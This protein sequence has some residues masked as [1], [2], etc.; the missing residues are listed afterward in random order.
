MLFNAQ[1]FLFL[2][3]DRWLMFLIGNMI[4]SM[5]IV[6]FW[7][8]K[9]IPS[10]IMDLHPM[11][12]SYI[13]LSISFSSYSTMSGSAKNALLQKNSDKCCLFFLC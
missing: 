9:I 2:D 3:G 6:L 10:S 5:V 4:S 13:G 1:A 11:I 12:R 8:F 7:K